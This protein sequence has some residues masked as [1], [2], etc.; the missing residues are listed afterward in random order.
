MDS[1]C[2]VQLLLRR[3]GDVNRHSAVLRRF[4][5]LLSRD[6]Q[7]VISHIYREGN[8]CADYIASRGHSMSFGLHEFPITDP[9]LCNW[10]L[11]DVQGISEPR[12]VVNES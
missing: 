5:A 9:S 3:D 12:L 7:V 1:K 10:I 11:Y 8:Y 6:W 2:A 4:Q